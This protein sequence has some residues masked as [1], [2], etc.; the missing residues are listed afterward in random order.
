MIEVSRR[1][2][3]VDGKPRI[4]MAGE[5]H[6]FRVARGEWEQRLRLAVE[7][8]C[9]T[10]ASYIPW[11]FH[12]LGDGTIDL[13]GVS[14]PERDLGAYIDLCAAHGLDFIARPGPFVMAELKNEG[15]PYRLYTDHP[16]IV[17]SGWDGIPAPTST[18]DYLAP[19]YL[20]ECDR[21]Y[22]AVMPLLSDRLATKG[23]PVTAVQLDNEVGMLAWVSNSPDLTDQS[24]DE[25]RDWIRENR[26]DPA[27]AYP[28]IDSSDE[29][30]RASIRTPNERWAG[31]LRIDLT[32]FMRRRFARYIEHLRTRAERNGVTGVPFCINI[33]GT[34]GGSGETFAIGISQLVDTFAGV[35]GMLSGSD[36]YVGDVTMNSYTDLYVMNAQQAAVHDAD[37]PV[38]SLEFEAGNGDYG[39]GFDL[40]YEPSTV[41]LKTRLHVAQGVRLI[42]YY[43]LAGG[44][45]PP[46]E[47][48]VGD[49]N[50]RLSFTGERH[51]T[52]APIGPEGQRGSTFGATRDAV[53]AVRVH[54]PWLASAVEEVDELTLGMVLDA[55]AT[56]Y[57]H[58][59]SAVMAAVTGDLSSHRGAAE[60]RALARSAL[61]SGHRFDATH[62]ERSAVRTGADG[63]PVCLM[64]ATARHMDE[65]VQ[66]RLVEHVERGGSLL[67][68]GPV[69]EADLSGRPCRV[70][71]E[72]LGLAPGTVMMDGPRSFPSV[73]AQAWMRPF[74]E[75]RVAWLQSLEGSAG[76][77]VLTDV[78]GVACGFEVTHGSGRAVVLAC[79]LPSSPT[80]FERV[81]DRLGVRRGLELAGD[82]PGVFATTTR[83][84]DGNRL[85]HVI[86]VSGH[87]VGVTVR[88]ADINRTAELQLPP[89]SG[90]MFPLG[91]DLPR[92]RLAWANA[93]I[94]DVSGDELVFGRPTGPAL[95]VEWEHRQS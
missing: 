74:P 57:A 63:R 90:H 77:V 80:L 19:A 73:V 44:I 30:W 20:A 3:L 31:A 26:P 14:S 39:G 48:A 55:Y 18:V 41:D 36:H 84:P 61:L 12:E 94:A 8:G 17:P 5:V 86:N 11:V 34:S 82:T 15:L 13:T 25:L 47:A 78:Q 27:A 88:V 75:T 1:R 91:L 23:G 85:L 7:I 35:E 64:V 54:E 92:G 62:L 67:A 45:N 21:W 65:S 72:E 10:I 89:H 79:A 46:L 56:E 76:E 2:L 28:L 81:M 59:N 43:L 16:E 32:R 83:D 93:E 71:A 58:P 52:A 29:A 87:L 70:F 40:Q 33:H 50:N 4:V 60:R 68:L 66:R 42:N 24:L 6:Y 95:E 37:Q 38:T 53:K 69:P 49:G 22:D 9:D 51:G